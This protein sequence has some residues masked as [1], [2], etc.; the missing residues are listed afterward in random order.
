[1][2]DDGNAAVFTG[3]FF[4]S[5]Q[6][7]TVCSECFVSFAAGTLQAITGAPIG[8]VLAAF[9]ADP[10]LFG[11][12]ATEPTTD[13]VVA[14]ES[15]DTTLNELADIEALLEADVTGSGVVMSDEFA[16]SDTIDPATLTD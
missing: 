3:T 1:M 8:D 12:T 4:D 5:G 2:S 16:Q 15:V 11:E 14:G 13:D 7:V 6:S 10:N 9:E